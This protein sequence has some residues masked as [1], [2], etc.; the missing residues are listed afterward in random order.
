VSDATSN[1]LAILPLTNGGQSFGTTVNISVNG[2]AGRDLYVR[3]DGS[4]AYVATATSA[5][6]PEMFIVNTDSNSGTYRQTL[7]SYD[8]SGMDPYGVTVVTSNKA[9]IVGNGGVEYQ[10]VDIANDTITNCSNTLG[11]FNVNIKGVASVVEQDGDAYSYIITGDSA[12]EFKII[13]GGP[14]G[15]NAITGT[16]D[17]GIFDPGYQT[18]FN[19]YEATY[20]TPLNTSISFQFAVADPVSGSCGGANY[21]FVGPDGTSGTFYTTSIGAISTDDDNSGYEN[22]GRCFRFRAYLTT[23]DSSATPILNDLRIN[24]SP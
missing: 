9:I 24:Y 18:A 7:S 20:S 22:P 11:D 23:T 3:S 21:V 15:Q 14:G 12:N 8:T 1:Q 5:T 13:Q 16:Y 10:V 19:R 6:K 17:S 2:A 4:R